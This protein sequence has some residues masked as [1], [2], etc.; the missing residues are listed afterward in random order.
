MYRKVIITKTLL[1]HSFMSLCIARGG[2]ATASPVK[3]TTGRLHIYHFAVKCTAWMV[4]INVE[5]DI[6]IAVRSVVRLLIATSHMYRCGAEDGSNTE[7]TFGWFMAQITQIIFV[8]FHPVQE[9][10]WCI[11]Y[12]G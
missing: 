5:F 9:E 2:S 8:R 6:S 3:S 11:L 4:Y 1:V 10:L 7:T 12:L